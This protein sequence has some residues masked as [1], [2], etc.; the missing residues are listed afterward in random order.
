VTT[1]AADKLAGTALTVP[2]G[3]AA[4]TFLQTESGSPT[5]QSMVS[6][7][8]GYLLM[9]AES[10]GDWSTSFVWTAAIQPLQGLGKEEMLTTY[11]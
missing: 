4:S 5:A 11:L 9:S 6:A 10:Q 2:Y 3:L 8:R 1:D 7:L